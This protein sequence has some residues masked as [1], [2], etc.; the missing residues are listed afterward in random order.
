[1]GAAMSKKN[2]EE[3]ETKEAQPHITQ[4]NNKQIFKKK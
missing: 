1:V 3:K 4:E 2:Q